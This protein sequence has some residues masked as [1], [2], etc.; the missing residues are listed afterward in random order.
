MRDAAARLRNGAYH[1]SIDPEIKMILSDPPIRI[2]WPRPLLEQ[3]DRLE[4][5]YTIPW[6]I[7]NVTLLKDLLTYIAAFSLL[8]QVEFAAHL[9]HAQL[10]NIQK[11]ELGSRDLKLVL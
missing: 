11:W 7:Q 1:H 10:F 4:L 9:L 6:P 3:L 8:M 2:S 5:T